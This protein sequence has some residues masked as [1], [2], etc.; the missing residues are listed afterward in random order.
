MAIQIDSDNCAE[1]TEGE[2][3]SK[4]ITSDYKGIGFTVAA[5]D[6]VIFYSKAFETTANN[7]GEP[8]GQDRIRQAFFQST[9]ETAEAKLRYI[10]IC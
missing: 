9:G 5:G 7:Q 3:G 10:L 8:F 2:I 1:Q 4:E 6:A